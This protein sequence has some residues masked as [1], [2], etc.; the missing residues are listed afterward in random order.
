MRAKDLMTRPVVTVGPGH[1]VRDVAGVLARNGVTALPVVD[2][3]GD[4]VGIVTEADV[5]RGRILPD[6]RGG[7][8][9]S[10]PPPR[11]VGEVMTTD[12]VTVAES[13]DVADV[14]RAMVD[15][16]LRAVPVLRGSEPGDR[17]VGILTRRDLMRCISRE[18]AL[19]AADVRHRLDLYSGPGRWTVTVRA[20]AVTLT[21]DCDD[22][23]DPTDR[24]VA[25]VLAAAV[26]G[27]CSVQVNGAGDRD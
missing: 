24:H 25:H 22:R 2:D 7:Y 15:R 26:P 3:D 5:M 11:T 23:D 19:V 13:A 4:L 16:G 12:V 9:P 18:D 21:D 14:V 6:P 27:V 8:V 17:L 20:G 1:P 10:A